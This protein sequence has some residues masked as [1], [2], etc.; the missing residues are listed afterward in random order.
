M[1]T[2]YTDEAVTHILKKFV[3]LPPVTK[4][5]GTLSFLRHQSRFFKR[6]ITLRPMIDVNQCE[7]YATL[8][9]Y[10]FMTKLSTTSA[11]TLKFARKEFERHAFSLLLTEKLL[12][13]ILA[14]AIPICATFVQN[15]NETIINQIH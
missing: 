7:F 3:E 1:I 5:E 15:S 6:F 14:S 8:S 4:L 2:D 10:I 12:D 13:P 11:L 9:A